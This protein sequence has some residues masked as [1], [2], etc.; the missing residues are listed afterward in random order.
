MPSKD[1]EETVVINNYCFVLTIKITHPMKSK[2]QL[3][4]WKHCCFK[5]YKWYFEDKA[6]W[7][8]PVTISYKYLAR[9]Q[10]MNSHRLTGILC[11]SNMV[12]VRTLDSIMV[13][14]FLNNDLFIH[15]C[16]TSVLH[17]TFCIRASVFSFDMLRGLFAHQ[18][19]FQRLLQASFFYIQKRLVFLAEIG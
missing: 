17:W 3:I 9:V 12:E 10:R 19:Y 8:F 2:D 13:I 4:C 14:H 11:K 15:W 5:F 18:V 7:P 6:V 1:E 16:A